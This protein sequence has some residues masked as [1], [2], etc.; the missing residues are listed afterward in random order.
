MKKLLFA[1]IAAAAC[2]GCVWTREISE[3]IVHKDANGKIIGYDYSEKLEQ[4]DLKPW[5]SH[6]GKYLYKQ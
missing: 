5:S 1:F 2:S 4:H 6:F 3:V